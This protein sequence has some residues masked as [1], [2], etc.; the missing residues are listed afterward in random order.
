MTA[1]RGGHLG[2]RGAAQWADGPGPPLEAHQAE[3]QTE[4]G[5][6]AVGRSLQEESRVEPLEGQTEAERV[7][8]EAARRHATDDGP[9][10]VVE[11]EVTEL[12]G[13]D[14]HDLA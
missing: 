9:P 14:R 4:H 10:H 13:Q 2:G 3:P 1:Q 8:D 12:V 5:E 11:L 6:G 7:E